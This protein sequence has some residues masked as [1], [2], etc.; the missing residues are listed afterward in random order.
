MNSDKFWEEVAEL[1]S[2]VEI[3]DDA[4][5]KMVET[6][7]DGGVSL[8]QILE[9]GRRRPS[10]P[11]FLRFSEKHKE[12]PFRAIWD[13]GGLEFVISYSADFE[14]IGVT[15]QALATCMD[16]D[17]DAIR[18]VCRKT[19]SSMNSADEL[20]QRGET[21]LASRGVVINPTAVKA[22]ILAVLDARE[23]YQYHEVIPELYFLL[24]QVLLPGETEA[25]KAERNSDM[26]AWAL[27]LSWAYHHKHGK[28]PSYRKLAKLIGV[29]PT[30]I[31]RMFESIEQFELRASQFGFKSIDP[32]EHPA[33]IDIYPTL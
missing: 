30:T 21:H 16:G 25:K 23:R 12:T 15:G 22:F 5:Q 14:K 19:L 31:S 28:Y 26:K 3:D 24:A 13:F 6:Y 7:Y 18:S 1:Y 9:L 27:M 11:S 8:Q 2:D 32:S 4:R 10:I 29:A 33:L 20:R 17:P